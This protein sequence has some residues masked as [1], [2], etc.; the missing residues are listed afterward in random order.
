MTDFLTF[1]ALLWSVLLLVLSGI[2][3]PVCTDDGS[4]GCQG[5]P[6]FSSSSTLLYLVM[7]AVLGLLDCLHVAALESPGV[8][9]MALKAVRG[10]VDT[11]GYLGCWELLDC[12]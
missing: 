3:T 7:S 8:T 1:P 10:T 4:K 5:T 11:Q 6:P 2:I 12:Q 9:V